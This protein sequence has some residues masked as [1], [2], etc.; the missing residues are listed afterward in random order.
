MTAIIDLPSGNGPNK[1]QLRCCH[2]W[3]GN[4]VIVIGSGASG[5]DTFKQSMQALQNLS[6][7]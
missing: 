5:A 3:L 6:A 7:S 2:A 1:S 4:F